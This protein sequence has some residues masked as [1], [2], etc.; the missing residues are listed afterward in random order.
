M[1]FSMVQE[2]INPALIVLAVV[3]YFVGNGIKNSKTVQDEY[4]PFILGI[5]GIVVAAVWV[6]A[7]TPVTNF[8]E[9]LMG[10]FEALTQ[11]IL[12]ASA[13]VYLN[14]LIKQKEKLE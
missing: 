6:F 11:G 1:D 9:I 2:F 10:I 4:I 13:P 8:Q 12:C 5:L 7:N 14:Q 3:L